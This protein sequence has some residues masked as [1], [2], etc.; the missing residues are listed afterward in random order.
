MREPHHLAP[1]HWCC[2]ERPHSGT[3]LYMEWISAQQPKWRLSSIDSSHQPKNPQKNAQHALHCLCLE[4][5]LLF[6]IFLLM[7]THCNLRSCSPLKTVLNRLGDIYQA[8]CNIYKMHAMATHHGGSGQP[9]HR[10]VTLNGKDTDVDIP[11]D[12]H[13]E[14]TGDFENIE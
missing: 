7:S 10:D 4:V 13:H 12:Y 14:N 8:Y 2:N 6:Y 9:L 3:A 1:L 5:N 11:H